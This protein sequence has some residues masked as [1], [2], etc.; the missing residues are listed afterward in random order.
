MGH[1]TSSN[2]RKRTWSKLGVTYGQ[3]S[4]TSRRCCRNSVTSTPCRRYKWT[5]WC[6]RTCVAISFRAP[7]NPHLPFTW[8][9]GKQVRSATVAEV[10][11]AIPELYVLPTPISSSAL[12]AAPVWNSVKKLI[13]IPLLFLTSDILESVSSCG[14]I[15]YLENST[16][17][18]KTCCRDSWLGGSSHLPWHTLAR[19]RSLAAW[20]KAARYC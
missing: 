4:C 16:S 9:A 3:Y 14:K 1:Q 6:W 7:Q 2:C 5:T 11:K 13:F 18:K 17:T 15:C 20:V 10:Q 8:K 12:V 19:R